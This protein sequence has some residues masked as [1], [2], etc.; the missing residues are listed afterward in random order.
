[1]TVLFGTLSK[2]EINKYLPTHRS[3]TANKTQQEMVLNFFPASKGNHK[4]HKLAVNI[5]NVLVSHYFIFHE[6]LQALDEHCRKVGSNKPTW[7][8]ITFYTNILCFL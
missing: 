3:R 6:M 4:N 7:L 5:L 2:M 1:M 8:P